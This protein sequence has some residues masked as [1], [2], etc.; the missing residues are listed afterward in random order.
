MSIEPHP[1]ERVGKSKQ[2]P[3]NELSLVAR[4]IAALSS[5][6]ATAFRLS[7]ATVAAVISA[8]VLLL[9]LTGASPQAQFG[10]DTSAAL[11]AV[12]RVH[13]GERPH[14]DFFSPHGSL[15]LALLAV[16]MA[17]I[18]PTANVLAYMPAW[19]M[20]PTALGAWYL[21]RRRMPAAPAALFVTVVALLAAGTFWMSGGT[22]AQSYAM[23]YNR[24]GWVLLLMAALY[25]F[26]EPDPD[27][28]DRGDA[29]D[30]LL[31][32]TLLGLLAFHKLNYAIVGCTMALIGYVISGRKR[33]R[34]R[35][36]LAGFLVTT[37]PLLLFV[38]F[39]VDRVLADASQLL[40]TA[41]GEVSTMSKVLMLV[42]ADLVP[43]TVLL[44]A[45]ALSMTRRSWREEHLEM[46]RMLVVTGALVVGGIVACLGNMQFG[47]VPTFALAA[48][49]LAERT[50]RRFGHDGRT[51]LLV[52]IAVLMALPF[53]LRDGVSIVYSAMLASRVGTPSSSAARIDTRSMSP[54]AYPLARGES[55]RGTVDSIIANA[56]DEFMT[57]FQYAA[58]VNDGLQLI[59]PHL[60]GS[61]RVMTIDIVNPFPFALLLPQPRR[62][63]FFWNSTLWNAEHRPPADSILGSSDLVM[64]PKRA[65]AVPTQRQF[66]AK[67]FCPLVDRDFSPLAESRLWL[68]MRRRSEA[69]SSDGW[70]RASSCRS[71]LETSYSSS[72]TSGSAAAFRPTNRSP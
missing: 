68:L 59:Q 2:Q 1:D 33:G 71:L 25:W 40:A 5:R 22:R 16:T 28:R 67:A 34:I 54:L 17:V 53:P 49:L 41:G 60:R 52:L 23:Q 9:L 65:I 56:S 38:E 24:L 44:M 30:D 32:G 11:D 19:L 62:N 6:T 61:D 35:G 48:F 3:R 72:V 57:S 50:R 27:R 7:G 43:M 29:L 4:S 31:G 51:G 55:E 58:W 26:L 13:N 69:V 64:L 8:C 39:R 70:A 10:W 21:A 36:V 14:V 18:G 47:S 12:W 37:L 20:M 45:L 42:R 15:H 63:V 66:L 46:L